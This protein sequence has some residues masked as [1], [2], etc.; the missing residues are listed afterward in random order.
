MKRLL[1]TFA[2]VALCIAPFS[3]AGGGDSKPKSSS[4][5]S[6]KNLTPKQ[7]AV[8]AYNQGIAQRDRAWKIEKRIAA[9][10]DDGERAKLEEKMA[11]TFDGAADAFKRAIRHQPR[12]FEAH[13]DLGYCLRRVGKY[14]EALKHYDIALEIEPTYANAIEYRGEAFLGLNRVDEAKEA[15]MTLFKGH[16]DQAPDLLTAFQSYVAKQQAAGENVDELAAWVAERAEIAGQ[17]KTMSQLKD[18]NW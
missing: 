15:Y 13:S 1:T 2:L 4:E 17:S 7:Q 9:E 3:F 5:G 6:E 10:S 8:A 12:M 16:S 18:S 11:K 14:E